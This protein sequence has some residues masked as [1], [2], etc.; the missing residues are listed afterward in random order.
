MSS[1][2]E[3]VPT[4]RQQIVHPLER[5]QPALP[6]SRQSQSPQRLDDGLE[7]IFGNVGVVEVTLGEVDRERWCRVD[8]WSRGS[9]DDVKSN[10]AEDGDCCVD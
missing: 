2:E 1:F 4:S 10:A 6:Q 9:V 7:E 3:F 8:R 5:S